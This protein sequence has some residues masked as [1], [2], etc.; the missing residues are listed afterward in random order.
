MELL[1]TFIAGALFAAAIY[2]A[3]FL[4]LALPMRGLDWLI[5]RYF[6]PNSRPKT[7]RGSYYWIF[8]K[9]MIL[10]ALYV[11]VGAIAVSVQGPFFFFAF[12]AAVWGIWH[13]SSAVGNKAQWERKTFSFRCPFCRLI[14]KPSQ[15]P[16]EFGLKFQCSYC[17]RLI[18]S[19]SNE[20]FGS[21]GPAVTVPSDIFRPQ[22][23]PDSETLCHLPRRTPEA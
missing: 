2:L 7:L 22:D 15:I 10:A 1:F 17:H 8:A 13:L 4:F 12:W 11:S 19:H 6:R 23:E 18:S 16:S 21:L 9:S 5:A 14:V 20:S 3:V